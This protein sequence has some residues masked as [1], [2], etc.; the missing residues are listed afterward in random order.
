MTKAGSPDPASETSTSGLA[1]R[2]LAEAVRVHE[3][4]LGAPLHEPLADEQGRAAGGGLERRII[5]R[6]GVLSPAPALRAAFASLRTA[7]HIAFAA[8]LI[9]A[10]IAGSGAARLAL[11]AYDA[12]PVNF[13]LALASLLGLH[14]VM[15][16]VWL[17]FMLFHPGGAAVG[18]LGGVVLRLA[19]RIALWLNHGPLEL[20]AL[21]AAGVA[22]ANPRLGRWTLSTISHS[23]WMAYLAGCLGMMLLLLGTRQYDFVWETTILSER[24]YVAIAR[25]L[26]APIEF[27][28]FP[29]PDAAQISGSRW[30]RPGELFTGRELWGGLLVG[31][32]VAYGVLP[33]ALALLVSLAGLL[34]ARAAYRLDTSRPGFARLQGRLI[35]LAQPV[36]VVDPDEPETE[37]AEEAAKPAAAIGGSGPVAIVGLEIEPSAGGWPPVVG[38]VEWWDLG[39]AEDR[40]SRQHI[41]RLLAAAEQPPRAVVAVCSLAATPDRGTGAF[42]ASLVQASPAPVVLVA[43]DGQRL[44]E[45]TPRGETEQRI[46]DWRTLATHAGIPGERVLDLDLDHLTADSR[47]R[48]G[49]LLG[50]RSEAHAAAP[51]AAR[52][53]QAFHLIT[54][55]A[56]AWKGEPGM[57]ER[58]ELQRAIARLWEA[59]GG[60]AGWRSL[61]DLRSA[62]LA[63]PAQSLKTAARRMVDLLPA[64]LRL[65]PRWLAAGAAGG[66][67][68]CVAA[69]ALVAPVAISALPAWAGLGA[70]LSALVPKRAA[71]ADD[72]RAIA[73]VPDL[74]PAVDAAAL[75]A[76]LLALQGREETVIGR[77]LDAAAGTETH[78]PPLD[79]PA[80][81]RDRLDGMQAR[82]AE[83]LAAEEAGA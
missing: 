38:D 37:E 16:L 66:A 19:R 20:A 24:A 32:L 69:A 42:L 63:R 72:N 68:A 18:L 43:T 52:L 55:H 54:I 51:P 48:L 40:T 65:D 31:C 3:E 29:V 60:G 53:A 58:A 44:R 9:A 1:P 14:T 5:A 80:A 46:A 49:R 10:V 56:E 21:R 28:G 81:V 11:G 30:T 33:R 4:A 57:A 74:G 62:D 70:A 17:V 8:G 73:A 75:F 77:V 7:T 79:S 13:F 76:M 34:R 36:G 23:M 25:A 22:L 61:L 6:A 71:P 78:L 64:R 47:Q 83:A 45:R 15:L 82:F 26:A 35:S 50:G 39:F 12:G 67:F 41:A 59:E 27:L 2:L